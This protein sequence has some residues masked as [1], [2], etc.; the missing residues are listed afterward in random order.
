MSGTAI[1]KLKLQA[2]ARAKTDQLSMHGTNH[3][4][5]RFNLF[6][7]GKLYI[8]VR[9]GRPFGKPHNQAD[10]I[11]VQ[12]A[13][14][15]VIYP[16]GKHGNIMRLPSYLPEEFSD[17]RVGIRLLLVWFASNDIHREKGTGAA[18]E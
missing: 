17:I 2:Y 15:L 1:L 5:E 12:G 14:A 7:V 3:M 11:A 8:R 10:D 9:V 18:L 6:P 4:P 16:A 13:V